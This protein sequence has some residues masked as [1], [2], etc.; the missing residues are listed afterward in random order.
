[1]LYEALASMEHDTEAALKTKLQAMSVQESTSS[2]GATAPR[3]F[4][5]KTQALSSGQPQGSCTGSGVAST[6]G[7]P[8]CTSSTPGATHAASLVKQFRNVS[9]VES[10]TGSAGR[11]DCRARFRSMEDDG[12]HGG[13]GAR[14]APVVQ[15]PADPVAVDAFLQ[16]GYS[17]AQV[18]TG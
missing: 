1:M 12:K 14:R 6:P 4:A 2:S 9:A 8:I 10:S 13:T 16:S 18:K 17:V 11:A 15:R 3:H 5:A 7:G